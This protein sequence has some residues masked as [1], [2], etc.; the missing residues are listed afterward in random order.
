MFFVVVLPGRYLVTIVCWPCGSWCLVH[1][2]L[3]VLWK[4][5]QSISRGWVQQSVDALRG[6]FACDDVLEL[7]LMSLIAYC[8]I[9]FRR[10][11]QKMG[12]VGYRDGGGCLK[13]G[14]KSDPRGPGR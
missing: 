7:E 13:V 14:L 2:S 3:P 6:V 5:P 11:R 12:N 4:L 8:N 10:Q 9:S 1:R